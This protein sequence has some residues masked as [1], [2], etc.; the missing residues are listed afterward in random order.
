M[1]ASHAQKVKKALAEFE[2]AVAAGDQQTAYTAIHDAL[3]EALAVHKAKSA[4]HPKSKAVA[5]ASAV[6]ADVVAACDSAKAAIQSAQPQPAP[7]ESPA[8]SQPATTEPQAESP[9]E[10]VGVPQAVGASVTDEIVDALWSLFV[11]QVAPS[12]LDWLKKRFGG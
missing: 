10:S 12:I 4:P 9:G 7:A 2:S 11:T 3:G 8:E 5:A 6:E 1:A